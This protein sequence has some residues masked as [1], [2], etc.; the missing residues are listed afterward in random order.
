MTLGVIEDAVKF[1]ATDSRYRHIR[2][3]ALQSDNAKT[4]TGAM[5]TMFLPEVSL[6][7]GVQISCFD[8]NQVH[9]EKNSDGRILWPF[10]YVI[11]T[12]CG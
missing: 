5:T 2:S 11:G 1:I 3:V 4:Y 12:A 9:D 6:T 7:S 10:N 8:H